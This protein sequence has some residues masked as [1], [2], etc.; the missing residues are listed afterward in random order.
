MKICFP[1]D[2]DGAFGCGECTVLYRIRT[3]FV[4][5]HRQGHGHLWRQKYRWTF[6]CNSR[7]IIWCYG[8]Q[9]L[10][11]NGFH[12][13]RLPIAS[14]QVIVGGREGI[15][16]IRE[17]FTLLDLRHVAKS[18]L[19]N[20]LNHRKCVFHTVIEFIDED[21]L[22]LLCCNFL[23]NIV[24]LYENTSKPVLSMYRLEDEF[25]KARFEPIA[26]FLLEEYAF[27][28]AEI[29]LASFRTR[30]RI[31]MKPRLT[32]GRLPT[33]SRQ[34]SSRRLIGDRPHWP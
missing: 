4:D 24:S 7:G 23:C 13:R 12:I 25:E 33:G 2:F 27:L 32:S 3:K 31:S 21:G 10:A 11:D 14:S 26:V 29:G 6:D 30:S 9:P 28:L 16:P 22:L 19:C 8:F 18:L 17:G 34:V 5:H 15:E 20:A 1:G